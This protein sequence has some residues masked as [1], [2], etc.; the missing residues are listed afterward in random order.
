M[1]SKLDFHVDSHHYTQ[2]AVHGACSA[3]RESML[4]QAG[5]Q[6]NPLDDSVEDFS[7]GTGPG[8]DGVGRFVVYVPFLYE[9][10]HFIVTV[11]LLA[12]QCNTRQ[13]RTKQDD[14]KTRYRQRDMK[15]FS[16]RR[17]LLR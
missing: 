4:F 2:N 5:L 7:G 11:A 1:C 9:K 15:T 17:Q 10:H 13:D 12:V 16:R 8:G 14:E 6:G 3:R